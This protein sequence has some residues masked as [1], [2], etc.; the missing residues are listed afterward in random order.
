M[1]YLRTL[2]YFLDLALIQLIDSCLA[3]SDLFSYFD[4]FTGSL[5]SISGDPLFAEDNSENESLFTDPSETLWNDYMSSSCIDDDDQ[6][7]SSKL[8]ARNPVCPIVPL[9]PHWPDLTDVENAVQAERTR[10]DPPYY[11]TVRVNG[12]SITAEE[13]EFHCHFDD[14]YGD[15][16]DFGLY[17]Y[18]IPVCALSSDRRVIDKSDLSWHI[19]IEYTVEPSTLRKSIYHKRMTLKFGY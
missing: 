11:V 6:E 7:Q 8:R 16:G 10:P 12:R 19:P 4:E 9:N 17:P 5:P 15:L 1:H 13:P 3:D 14:N 2:T 18:G